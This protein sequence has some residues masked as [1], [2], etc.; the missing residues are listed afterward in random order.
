MIKD[1]ACVEVNGLWHESVNSPLSDY[2]DKPTVGYKGATYE[3]VM[4]D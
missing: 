1:R 2:E 3:G 4:I